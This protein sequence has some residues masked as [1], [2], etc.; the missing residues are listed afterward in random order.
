MMN[1][2]VFLCLFGVGRFSSAGC[3]KVMSK[4]TQENAGEERIT[5]KSKPMMN[6]VSRSRDPNVLATTASESPVKT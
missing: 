3:L 2:I 1:G 4:T 5:A 6:L